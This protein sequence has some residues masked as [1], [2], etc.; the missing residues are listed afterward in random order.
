MPDSNSTLIYLDTNVYSRPFDDQTQPDIQE[1]AN[2]FLEIVREIEAERF[3]LLCSD[4]LEFEVQNIL[5]RKKRA[6]VEDYL[7]LCGKHIDSSEEVLNLGKS[8]QSK[9]EVRARDA[10]HIASAIL[11]SA[12]YFLSC[13]KKVTQMKQRRCYR[14]LTRSY[15]NEYFSVMDPILFVERMRKGELE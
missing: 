12:R 2:A 8:I 4:I 15:R 14:R 10:L 9:C 1:E 5:D 13:D 3:T 11:G 6:Q 7:G